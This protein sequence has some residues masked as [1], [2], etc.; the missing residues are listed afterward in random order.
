[1][2]SRERVLKAINHEEPDRV[3][4]DLGG[5]VVTGIM[6]G[7][8]VRLRQRLGLEGDVKVYDVF[9][10]L[11]EVT[12]D[13]VEK[14]G[15][16]VLPVQPEA[17]HFA[18]LLNRDTRPWTLFDGTP[19]LMPGA[20][21]VE[22][23]PN[24]DWLLHENGDPRRPVIA[25]M[26]QGGF[27]FDDLNAIKWD[28][29]FTPPPIESLRASGWN[30][31]TGEHLRYLQDRARL[32]RRTTDKA[33]LLMAGGLGPPMV[34]SFPERLVLLVTEQG[35]VRELMDLGAEVALENLRLYWEALGQDVDVIV[36]S[37]LDYGGQQRELFSPALFE[38]LFVP[39]YRKQC[40]WIHRHTPW[41]TFQHCCGSI[42]NLIEP[43]M[44]AG[45]DVL[46]P[47]QTSAQGMDP[48]WLKETFGDRI[49]FWGGGVDTQRVL[50]FGTPEE[51]RQ[52]VAR[53]I[54]IFG[55]GGGFVWNPIHNVQYDV[56]PENVVA[57]IE[58]V[59]EFGRYPLQCTPTESP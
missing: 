3:P 48:R 51:V 52:D 49:T 34:G 41:K 40:D 32:L 8:L 47:V 22:V 26:P 6:A 50:S 18:H 37:A 11:G 56:P 55:P 21:E 29:D 57:A 23:A 1:M 59:H 14:L 43:L 2:N 5:S 25:R 10:M 9:Q 45:I 58:A 33:L 12:L 38:E 28:P 36:V 39:C 42:P 27:Y 20:F 54:E 16:D 7:A 15:I 30:R 4:I 17:I 19:V 31:A 13:L 44:R 24:G 46:N 35:Y 53:R